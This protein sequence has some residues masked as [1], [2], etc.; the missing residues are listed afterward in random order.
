MSREQN[1]E[2]KRD[3]APGITPERRKRINRLKKMIVWTVFLMILLPFTGC[4]LLGIKLYQ[5]NKS[6]EVMAERIGFLERALQDSVDEKDRLEALLGVNG[7]IWQEREAEEAVGF[8]ADPGEVSGNDIM[9]EDVSLNDASAKETV[10]KVYLTFDDGP[11]IYT[12]ELLDILAEYDVKATFFVTGKGKERYGD[13]YR[14]IVEEGHTL[15]MHSYSHEYANMYASLENFQSDLETLRDYL[16]RETGEVSRFYRFPG[17]SSN[18]VSR[19]DIRE[20]AV[21][22]NAMDISYF[23]WNISAGD[24]TGAYIGSEQIVNRVMSEL[25]SHQTAVVLMHDAA[26]K[27]STVEAL[28]KLIEE[29][30]GMGDGTEILPITEETVVIQHV[31]VE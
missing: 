10:R 1:N 29:I 12:E 27:H 3:E 7:E 20:L 26:D 9:A 23:D 15:G 25:P 31:S 22:L 18:N 21:Y 17:G 16:Y 6:M 5:K 24:A 4:V 14:R 13:T 8:L 2:T 28:P 19:T 30:Q 11:S